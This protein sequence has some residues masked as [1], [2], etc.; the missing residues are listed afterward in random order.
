MKF[1][2]GWNHE[3]DIGRLRGPM[4][5]MTNSCLTFYLHLQKDFTGQV[6]ILLQEARNS[7]YIKEL[8]VLRDLR[9]GWQKYRVALPTGQYQLVFEGT[10]KSPFKSDFALDDVQIEGSTECNGEHTKVLLEGQVFV[11]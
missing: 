6:R 10:V 11:G 7:D 4:S 9:D 8:A 2:T 1:S 5:T 3:G